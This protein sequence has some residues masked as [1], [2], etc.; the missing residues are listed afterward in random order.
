MTDRPELRC[1]RYVNPA[2]F[3]PRHGTQLVRLAENSWD[4]ITA[5]QLALDI[6]AGKLW[7]W[8]VDGT[9]GAI[10]LLSVKTA[11]SGQDM[12]W[13]DGA[14]GNGIVKMTPDIIAD[15]RT[16]A[17]SYGLSHIRTMSPRD[18]QGIPQQFG[19]VP[20]STIW[21]LEIEDGQQGPLDH[22]AEG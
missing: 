18:W 12:L 19:F 7:L 13:V 6:R 3:G 1:L 14:A 8:D 17:A 10:I 9:E 20:V 2:D 5:G 11:D 22:D 21:E 16:I 4:G 15:L